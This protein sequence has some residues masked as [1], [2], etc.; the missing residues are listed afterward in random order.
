MKKLVASMFLVCSV[1]GAQTKKDTKPDGWTGNN[2]ILWPSSSAM[3]A[4]TSAV[5]LADG[6]ASWAKMVDGMC[7]IT[8]TFVDDVGPVYCRT[9]KNEAGQQVVKCVWKP[10][11]AEATQ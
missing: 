7:Q 6:C 8:V 1:L 9:E 11:K 10:K 3:S 2:M 4:T 5:S